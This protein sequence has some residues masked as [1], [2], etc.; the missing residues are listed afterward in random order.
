[1]LKQAVSLETDAAAAADSVNSSV[2]IRILRK[3]NRQTALLSSAGREVAGIFI[4][5]DGGK[6]FWCFWTLKRR[7]MFLKT[8]GGA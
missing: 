4:V 2:T 7:L 8:P 6:V 1:M 3:E 5:A